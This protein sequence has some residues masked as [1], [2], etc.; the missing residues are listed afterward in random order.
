MFVTVELSTN[1]D[2]TLSLYDAVYI[3]PDGRQVTA[4]V[5][6]VFA[7]NELFAEANTVVAVT[8]PG[9]DLG[10]T[11]RFEALSM[12]FSNEYP[13]ILNVPVAGPVVP[14]TTTMPAT[15]AGWA[16]SVQAH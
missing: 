10:G 8:F 16:L 13:F 1:D 5:D 7:P 9:A 2:V 15:T 6:G 11:L 3:G 4:S 14:D 12:D